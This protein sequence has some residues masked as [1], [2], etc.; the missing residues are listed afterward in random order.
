MQLTKVQEEAVAAWR[1]GSN[2]RVVAVPG[3]GKSAVLLEACV[4]A[5]GLCLI[6]AYNHELCQETKSRIV[7]MGLEERVACMTFHG[8]ATYCV[9]PTPDDVALQDVLELLQTTPPK[10]R[11]VHVKHMLIDEAQDLRG[12]FMQL[13]PRVVALSEDTHC[14]LYTSPSPRDS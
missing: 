7:Q 14:L 3:A 1:A 6:L 4:E 11:L 12:S 5:D 9:A 2:V 13:V 8:L 10:R